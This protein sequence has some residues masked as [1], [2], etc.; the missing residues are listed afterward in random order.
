V[1]DEKSKLRRKILSLR[2]SLS[3]R[4]IEEKSLLIKNRLFNLAEY[5]NSKVIMFYVSARSEVKTETMIKE[6]LSAKRQ[7]LNE[8]KRIV[9][10]VTQLKGK[11][12]LLSKLKDY[13]KELEPG[14]FNI[15]EPKKEFFR[16]LKSEEVD[17]VIVPGIAFDEKGNRLGYGGGFYDNFLKK[18]G[19]ATFLKWASIGLAFETQIVEEVPVGREDE[20]VDF[21]ITEK[22]IIGKRGQATF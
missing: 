21:I 2:N 7:D 6:S 19:Q 11:K 9:V 4:E 22:R 16:P 10:P 18:R 15:L 3:E 17:L 5:K 8:N 13:N 1:K 12:L 20:K 14:T